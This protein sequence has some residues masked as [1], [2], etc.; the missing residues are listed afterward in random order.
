[1]TLKSWQAVALLTAISI[2]VS[3]AEVPR[4][5]WFTMATL[6]LS[7][8][9]ASLALMGTAALLG[10]RFQAVES[11]FGGLDRVYQ[12]H[13][14]LGVWALV[15]ASIHFTFRAGLREWDTAAILTLP[16]YATRLVRQLSLVALM[17]IVVL[18][19]NRNIPYGTWRWWHKLSGLA[20][21]IV[22]LHWLSIKSPIE[23]ASPAGIWLAAI[24]VLGISA[25]AYKLLL[26][27]LLARH[28]EYRIVK[29][30]PGAAA[31]H[32]ELAPVKNPVTFVPGQFA[33][34]TIKEEGLREPHPFTIAS[35]GDPSSNVDFVIRALGDYTNRLTTLARPGMYAEVY[36]PYGRFRRRAGASREIWIAGGVGIS[37]F[38]AWLRD[39]SA[40]HFDRV[41]FFYFFTP[42]REF[43]GADVVGELARGRNVELV[44]IP[45][46]PGDPQFVQRFRDIVS[47]AGAD[48][49]EISFCGP[50]GLLAA[51][52]RLMAEAGVP[53]RNL[54]YE[55]FEF[56]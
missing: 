27:P 49:V 5:D 36:A 26:Y 56:R 12:A 52:S 2:V 55:Y 29:V 51:V 38:I 53:R 54:H 16:A 37:P 44:A 20:F 14:W 11:L 8:G 9:V 28:A 41:T 21:V 48:A 22:V 42:G 40:K 15:F 32:L 25:A 17:T 45:S 33:F 13:K 31:V 1:M 19:L 50:K 47:Q 34:L 24:A 35:G 6:S 43:P 3:L 23:L 18:A 4:Q 10:G 46:G 30:S 7:L 39:P